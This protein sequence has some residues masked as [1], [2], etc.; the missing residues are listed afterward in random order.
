LVAINTLLRLPLRLILLP[1]MVSD[2]PPGLPGIQ[3]A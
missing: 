1:M 3:R 2:S